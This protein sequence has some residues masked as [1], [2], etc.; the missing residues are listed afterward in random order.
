MNSTRSNSTLL[1]E[2]HAD[3]VHVCARACRFAPRPLVV[4][5]IFLPLPLLLSSSQ[6]P[7]PTIA[8]GA[9]EIKTPV[10]AV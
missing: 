7:S 9:D 5:T 2:A 6:I 8:S 4:Q 10:A 3:I 1:A